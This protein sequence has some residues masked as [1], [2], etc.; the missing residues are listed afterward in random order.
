[1]RKKA[2]KETITKELEGK[3]QLIDEQ[4]KHV[5]SGLEQ[6]AGVVKELKVKLGDKV[7][8]GSLVALVTV[9]TGGTVAAAAHRIPP[10]SSP[11]LAGG[12]P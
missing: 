8:E 1:M 3:K 9:A 2:N 4:L 10:G 11:R 7:S 6:I 5:A 12:G